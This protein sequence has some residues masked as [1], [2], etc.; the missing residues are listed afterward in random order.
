MLFLAIIFVVIILLFFAL[1][2]KKLGRVLLCSIFLT[3]V[4]Q[5]GSYPFLN[6]RDRADVIMWQIISLPVLFVFSLIISIL[7]I[8]LWYRR[9]EGRILEQE[10]SKSGKQRGVGRE[11]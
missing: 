5:Y 6:E 7:F 10:T 1:T 3:I 11:T 2:F 8:W 4:F 9:K